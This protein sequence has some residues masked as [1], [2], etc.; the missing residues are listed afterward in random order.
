LA[1]RR[2]LVPTV[3]GPVFKLRA[4]YRLVSPDQTSR[5][6]QYSKDLKDEGLLYQ[7]WTFKGASAWIS[8][9]S[10]RGQR[11]CGLSGRILI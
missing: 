9:E 11:C 3:A 8:S 7:F 4:E 5:V 2:R 6:A 10:R 1:S